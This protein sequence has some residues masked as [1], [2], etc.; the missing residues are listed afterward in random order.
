MGAEKKL[1][2]INEAFQLA[3]KP[4]QNR[5]KLVVALKSTYDQS[6]DKEDFNEKFI[7]FLK[8]AMI[9]YRRE[10]AVEQVIDFVAKFVTSFYQM[11]EGD[12]SEEAEE[13]N[14]LMN[15]VFDFLLE[16]HS[17]NSHAVRFR[18]C[19]LVNKILGTMPENAQID[20]DLFDKINKA[21]LI[22]L[23]DKFSSVRI[24]AA[25]ALSRLQ[26]PK[27]ENCPVVNI[28]NTLLENDSNSEV[29]RAVL[30]CIAPSARTLPKIVGRTMDV[31][32]SVR[33]LAYEVL[34]EKVHMRALS[35]A[36][37][38]KLL[39]QG[40]ND[41][42]DAVKEVM[43][44]KLLQA[45]LRFTDGDVLELLHRLDVENCAEVAISALKAIF[46]LSPLHDF[47]QNFKNLDS[48]KLIPLEDLTPENVLYWRCL[49]EY[50]KSKGEECEDLLEQ[51]LPET[52]VYADY[53]LSYLQNMPVLSE[54]QREDFT[55]FENLMTK[56]FIGQQLIL[57]IGCM[58]IMEEGGRNHLLATLQ[59]ILILPATSTA[60][61]SLLV[62][63]LLIIVEDD[64]RRIQVIAEIVSEVHEPIITVSQPVDAAEIRKRELKL[65]EVKVK[66]FEAKAALEECIS[67]QDFNRASVLKEKITELE[68]IKND[69]I[70]EADQPEI[71]EMHVKK[72]DPE[73]LL[74]CLMMCYE[75]LK[76]MSLSKGIDPTINEIIES[77]ILPGITNVHP[78]VRNMAV[79]C[80]GCCTLQNKEFAQQQLALLLQVLQVDNIKVKL[81][82]LK[83]LFDQLMLFGIEPFKA[84]RGNDSQNEDANIRTENC[85]GEGET[86][87]E[88]E[89]AA[90]VQ[91]LLQL[92]SGFLD[93]E[94]SE[95]RTEA[96]E[97]IAK[98]MFSG[99]L[100][101]AKLLSRL[102]LLWYNPVTEEDTQLRHCLGV[103][104]PLFAYAN[105]FN[106]ECFEE[107]Y[108]PTLQTLLNAPAT[109]PLAEIDIS[110]V[111]ELFVDLTRPSGLMAQSKKSQDYQDL[112]VH[113]SLAMKIC[114]EIL[115]DPTAPDVRLHAKALCSL[116]LSSSFTENFLV[117]L[118]EIL[119]KV[120]DK[121]CQKAIQKIKV[122]LTKDP[123]VSKDHCERTE[124]MGLSERAQETDITLPENTIQSEEVNEDNSKSTAKLRSTRSRAGKGQRKAAA[125]VRSVSRRKTG[126]TVKCG[127][128]SGDEIP[129]AV[130]ISSSRPSRRAK[131]LALEKT[132]MNLSAFLS[133]EADE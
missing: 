15:Y 117:L 104:F 116:E 93:S 69:L 101:S 11:E 131:T 29:R 56:E 38:V 51:M 41:R 128:E 130:P 23:K 24:Q 47:V 21:M 124:E 123:N 115:M 18:T 14:L 126:T 109:S 58:D 121:W 105:R 79:L 110:N 31:K 12:G 34:A 133:K 5:E 59:K 91:S 81:S 80:L 37:R 1:L 44:K 127:S 9:I 102:I 84:R 43:K 2:Q 90:T 77:L 62:E 57:I 107:A 46:S 55:S 99:R 42:S 6:K 53:L 111:S 120:K 89:K 100:V 8:Y 103:F 60:L 40:L 132:R 32:E 7:H 3:Q 72:N 92:L 52:A 113:D 66:L 95:L 27:D 112:T 85:E 83:V 48:R 25:L 4:Y 119:E 114:N 49:C 22:R 33:K 50:L 39:Q 125:E 63:R 68:H 82:A 97:G 16:S 98:L 30:S 78:A 28:Y 45:W 106:Q 70:K 17:A 74:K 13:D 26:D 118:N 20:D 19:Q 35:I 54:E 129:Q 76:I 75:L 88:E 87:E 10:P 96:A 64:D 108:L 67:L 94:F 73:T 86:T 61:I 71:K 36:Q 65:A 122:N